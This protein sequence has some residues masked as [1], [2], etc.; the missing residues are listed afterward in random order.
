L[1]ELYGLGGRAFLVLNLAPVGCYP[2]FLAGSSSELDAFGC[3]VSYNNAVVEYNNMLK[4]T[5]RQTREALPNASLIYVDTHS[6][7]LE[8]FRHPKSHGTVNA[9][10]FVFEIR[11]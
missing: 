3:M 6:V 7:L 4:E 5:L 9:Q 10:G 11:L 8:L 1:K 2:S